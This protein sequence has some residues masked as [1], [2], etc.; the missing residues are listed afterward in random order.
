VER[1][2]FTISDGNSFDHVE[3]ATYASPL[4]AEAHAILIARE[5]SEDGDTWHGGWISV[6]DT[7]AMKSRWCRSQRKRA[8]Q[9]GGR[10]AEIAASDKK[11][12]LVDPPRRRGG[13]PPDA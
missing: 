2:R 11:I 8:H 12:E 5:L 3:E 13:S 6:T 7:P 10:P 1:Y 9:V 4:A